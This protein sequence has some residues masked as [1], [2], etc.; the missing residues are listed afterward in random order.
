MVCLNCI[1]LVQDKEQLED[2][3]KYAYLNSDS[4]KCG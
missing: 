2:S 1:D 3:G 4:I